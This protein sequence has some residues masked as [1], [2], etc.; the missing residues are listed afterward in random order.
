MIRDGEDPIGSLHLP[1]PSLHTPRNISAGLPLTPNQTVPQMGRPAGARSI[2][3]LLAMPAD[4]HTHIAFL[5][6]V[7]FRDFNLVELITTTSD[8]VHR[9]CSPGSN[10]S[11]QNLA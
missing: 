9:Y 2:Q 4:S 5:H 3:L 11:T 1:L 6:L 8:K 10:S 7:E